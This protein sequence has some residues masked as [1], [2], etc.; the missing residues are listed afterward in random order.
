MDNWE[1]WLD[2]SWLAGS[3]GEV[4]PPPVVVG[5][6]IV[7]RVTRAEDFPVFPPKKRVKTRREREEEEIIIL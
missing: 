1:G 3:W 4:G 7:G 6:G 2:G 5:G